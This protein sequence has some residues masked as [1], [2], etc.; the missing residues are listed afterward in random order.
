MTLLPGIELMEVEV[1]HALPTIWHLLTGIAHGPTEKE[2]SRMIFTAIMI[3]LY[4]KN[5]KV[6]TFQTMM[7]ILLDSCH[8]TKQGIEIIQGI[9]FCC[10]YS[11]IL[12]TPK[13]VAAATKVRI[14]AL[15]QQ[16]A[17][18]VDLDNV[19]RRWEYEMVLVLGRQ[20]WIIVQGDL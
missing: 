13:K 4:S 19:N 1:M 11:H 5:Q 20:L 8:M 7:G 9:G 17:F 16:I 10:S 12:N 2:N 15:K 18:R 3:L 6:N 14:L